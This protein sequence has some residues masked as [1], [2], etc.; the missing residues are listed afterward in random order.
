[1]DYLDTERKQ[2]AKKVVKAG[3]KEP[4]EIIFVEVK[5][6][7]PS[8]TPKEKAV[9]EAVENQRVRFETLKLETDNS[10]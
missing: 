5:S 10:I 7:N 6:G 1:M 4:L 2:I 8:L 3:I 9:K